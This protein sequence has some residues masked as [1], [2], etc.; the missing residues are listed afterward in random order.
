MAMIPMVS[1]PLIFYLKLM[2]YLNS[3]TGINVTYHE[4]ESE[5]LLGINAI[6]TILI[7]A[8]E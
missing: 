7:L 2:K 8:T 1:L 6:T 5:A 3:Q 4:L